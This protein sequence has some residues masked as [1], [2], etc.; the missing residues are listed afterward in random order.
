N[1]LY[2]FGLDYPDLVGIIDF[3]NDKDYVF[4]EDISLDDIIWMGNQPTL[5]EKCESNGVKHSGTIKQL[6][7]F[8]KANMQQGRKVHF[9]P[10]Y[11]SQRKIQIEDLVGIPHSQVSK[12]AS[13][14]LIEAVVKLRA[15][16]DE[17]EIKDMSETLDNVTYDMHVSAM[18]MAKEGVYEREIA[19][20]IEGLSMSGGGSVAYPVILSVNGEIL[21]NH[22]HGNILKNGQLLLVDA[23]AESTMRYATD[24]TRTF[25]VGGKFTQQQ[26]EIYEIVLKAEVDSIES[27]K[28]GITYQS[29]HFAAAKIIANGLKDIG[30]MK[31]NIDDAVKE[32]AHAMFFP[33]GLGHMMGLDVHDMEDLGENYV[34][35][36]DGTERSKQFGTA[37]LRM[38]RKLEEGFVMTAEP[39]I[40]F[41]PALINTWKSEKKFMDFINY[42]RLDKYM[43]FGGIRI[44][45]DILVTK[46]SYKVLGDKLIPKTVAEIEKVM[47]P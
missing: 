1:F 21:H 29:I 35:Y 37:Y 5:K 7:D 13:V 31:G 39:G 45:D 15:V 40:Y 24:I 14:E 4:G 30:I 32:G 17:Y 12:H 23:G 16:K 19:G 47:L 27:I 38:G 3:D 34:G 36:G 20:F 2:F 11:R 10:P 9:L 25:P 44:E 41:I 18:K 28:P 6:N 33:H 42:D 8:I 26:K 43:N 46:N 22:Y